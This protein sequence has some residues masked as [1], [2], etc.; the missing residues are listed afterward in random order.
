MREA[1][2]A[3][4]FFREHPEATGSPPAAGAD[5]PAARGAPS[6]L[7]VDNSLQ[8]AIRRCFLDKGTPAFDK[9]REIAAL[10]R[11]ELLA[12][13]FFAGPATGDFSS[14]RGRSDNFTTLTREHSYTFYRQ[15]PA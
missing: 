5:R 7:S 4:A 15:Y 1:D 14:S 12:G 6:K 9:R 13:G 10:V 8:E 3:G 11:E 2:A